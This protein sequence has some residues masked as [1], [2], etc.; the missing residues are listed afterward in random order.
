MKAPKNSR[1]TNNAWMRGQ[2]GSRPLPEKVIF[3]VFPPPY[4]NKGL[5]G[6][7]V[8]WGGCLAKGHMTTAGVYLLKRLSV[9]TQ[10]NLKRSPQQNPDSV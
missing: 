5:S 4:R 7:T 10:P 6:G 3:G 9:N 2:H 8:F 1:L